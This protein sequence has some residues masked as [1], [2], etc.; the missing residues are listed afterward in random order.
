MVEA[1]GKRIRREKMATRES[2]EDGGGGGGEKE[3]VS[4]TCRTTKDRSTCSH[5]YLQSTILRRLTSSEG[6]HKVCSGSA[7][8]RMI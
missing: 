1:R 7:K 5:K 8:S 3:R 6:Q 4:T 2:D